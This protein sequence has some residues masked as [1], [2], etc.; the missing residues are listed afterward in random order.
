MRVSPIVRI[1]RVCAVIVVLLRGLCSVDADDSCS[2]N[3]TAL[4][5]ATSLMQVRQTLSLGNNRSREGQYC[6]RSS[7]RI[8]QYTF[9][10]SFHLSDEDGMGTDGVTAHANAEKIHIQGVLSLKGQCTRLITHAI[11]LFEKDLLGLGVV[12]VGKITLD[13]APDKANIGCRCY[14]HAA[15]D[16][17]F[18][19][20]IFDEGGQP[21]NTR[22]LQHSNKRVTNGFPL[23]CFAFPLGSAESTGFRTKWTFTDRSDADLKST[24]HIGRKD[25][26][27]GREKILDHAQFVVG[28]EPSEDPGQL[29]QPRGNSGLVV[30]IPAGMVIPV[31]VR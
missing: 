9:Y 24:M 23:D 20:L 26:R 25:L 7:L 14:T 15:Q 18:R 10:C 4:A 1:Q 28:G 27:S 3:G 17:G 30:P 12:R 13:F 5:D 21:E 16:L 11:Q 2:P 8:N 6:R 19:K 22:K 31:P 29:P